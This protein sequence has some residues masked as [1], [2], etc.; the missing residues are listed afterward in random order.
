MEVFGVFVLRH[1]SNK[2]SIWRAR[3][4][5]S[6]NSSPLH[7][8]HECINHAHADNHVC[9]CKC[10]AMHRCMMERQGCKYPLNWRGGWG[11]NPSSVVSVAKT[12]YLLTPII[13][14]LDV[15]L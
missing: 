15:V 8:L 4:H 14:C 6:Q 9:A 13:M 5:T 7:T 1:A 2:G 10:D 12:A 3:V 11:G